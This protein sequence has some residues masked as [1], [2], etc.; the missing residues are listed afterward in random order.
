MMCIKKVDVNN[1]KAE[2]T[3]VKNYNTK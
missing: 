3:T 2:T 1:V